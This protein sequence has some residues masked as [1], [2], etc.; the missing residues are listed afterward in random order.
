M[1]KVLATRLSAVVALSIPIAFWQVHSEHADAV[2]WL[3]SPSEESAAHLAFLQR[4]SFGRSFV[5]Y[6]VAGIVYV[7]LVDL[8]SYLLRGGWWS[9]STAA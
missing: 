8:V 7:L 6:L 1:D 2:R 5:A 9:R 3:A 4:A